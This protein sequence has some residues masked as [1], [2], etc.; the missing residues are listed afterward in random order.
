MT[1]AAI[2]AILSKLYSL[3]QRY[4]KIENRSVAWLD[5]ISFQHVTQGSTHGPPGRSR[6][7]VYAGTVFQLWHFGRRLRDPVD[8]VVVDEA[9]QLC[10]GFLALVM[11]S[12][13]R[14]ARLVL[15]G[16]PQQL[17]PIFTGVYPMTIETLF[18]SILDFLMPYHSK[19]AATSSG[20][21]AEAVLLPESQD[22]SISSQISTIVQLSENFR[23]VQ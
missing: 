23:Y 9:G 12:L 20:D 5:V 18:G 3:V 11:R 22:T 13:S 21:Q 1:H 7:H 8:M 6:V 4:R 17:A 15:A 14:T 19:A 16:D 2:E 10:L